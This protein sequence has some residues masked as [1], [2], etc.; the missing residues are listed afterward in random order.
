[1]YCGL[2]PC[3][4]LVAF[5]YC[6]DVVLRYWRRHID[7]GSANCLVAAWSLEVKLRVYHTFAVL[8]FKKELLTYFAELLTKPEN[9]FI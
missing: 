9:S 8:Y 5:T 6:F 1:M 2:W 7:L 4:S 3:G